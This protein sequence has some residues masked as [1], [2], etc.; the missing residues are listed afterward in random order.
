MLKNLELAERSLNVW[1]S[2]DVRT[3]IVFKS[4][5]LQQHGIARKVCHRTTVSSFFSGI[6]EDMFLKGG[7]VHRYPAR[8]VYAHT[9]AFLQVRTIGR[10]GPS[11]PSTVA[12]IFNAD[13]LPVR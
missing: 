4:L 12:S 11:W 7:R 13:A 5:S 9:I 10:H 6:T 8:I 2:C 3:E 1:V